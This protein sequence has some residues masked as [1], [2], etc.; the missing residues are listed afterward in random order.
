[1]ADMF[2]SN[3][4][5]G[6]AFLSI[7]LLIGTS[8]YASVEKLPVLDAF[9][10]SGLSITTLGFGISGPATNIGK[11]FTVFFALIG[12]GTIFYIVGNIFHAHPIKK[13]KRRR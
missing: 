8:F 10:L 6:I 11:I 2:Y 12:I 4:I 13:R 3:S 1:M 7:L 9:Y 5:R